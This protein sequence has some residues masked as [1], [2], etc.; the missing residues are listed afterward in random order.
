MIVVKYGEIYRKVE[1]IIGEPIGFVEYKENEYENNAGSREIPSKKAAS[2]KKK[3][4][5]SV[6][7]VTKD[8]DTEDAFTPITALPITTDRWRIK[9]RVNK[10]TD[11]KKF[12][13][14]KGNDGEFFSVDIS[15]AAGSEIRC[16]FFNTAAVK[17]FEIL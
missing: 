2:P 1:E 13:T 7:D 11:I 8:D 16:T 6:I 17:F 14:N 10:K 3:R 15:D 12:H 5:T 4:P 9:G